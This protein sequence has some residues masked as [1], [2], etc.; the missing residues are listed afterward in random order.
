MRRSL[1]DFDASIATASN[2]F[3]MLKKP[4]RGL[5]YMRLMVM[6]KIYFM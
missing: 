5:R 3:S 1:Q 4:G 2:T 6:V